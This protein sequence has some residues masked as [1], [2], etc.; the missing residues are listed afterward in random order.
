MRLALLSDIHGNPL[1]LEAVLADIQAQGGVDSYWVLGD[2]AALG[3]DPV[4]VLERLH[5]LPDAHFTRG[6]T[7]RYLITGER[8][9]PSLQEATSNADLVKKA[10][11]V[12]SSFAWTQGYVSAA[13]WWN[14]L[15]RLPL[16]LRM[17]LPDGT[18]LLGIHAAP[19]TDD[20]PGIHPGLSEEE[21]YALLKPAEAD[22]IFVGHT[23]VPLER[24]VHGIRVV[25]LG[26]VSIPVVPPLHAR[27]ALLEAG[28]DGYQIQRRQVEYDRQAVI[29]AVR[30]SHHPAGEFIIGSMQGLMISHWA[31]VDE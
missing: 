1:A 12:A 26:S 23:H 17:T 15:S 27:Y 21:L 22:L 7:D 24:S 20:G 14:W 29:E 4:T 10:V 25:N 11:E 2:H 19:G 13:G 3:Y 6:N 9:G 16:E 18:R 28:N 30:L 5:A 31:K 8:P